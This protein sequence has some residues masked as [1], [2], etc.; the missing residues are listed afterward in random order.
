MIVKYWTVVY[1]HRHGVDAFP[2][3]AHQCEDPERGP[4]EEEAIEALGVEYEPD[5]DEWIEILNKQET[6]IPEPNQPETTSQPDPREEK[7][8]EVARDFFKHN[9]DANEWDI[10]NEPKV[11]LGDDGAYVQMWCWFSNEA[12]ENEEED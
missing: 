4:S 5:R 8:R 9:M 2:I 7:F 11:S 6:N 12:I 3:F 1:S 10:D